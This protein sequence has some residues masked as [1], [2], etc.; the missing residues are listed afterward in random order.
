MS[1]KIARFAPIASASVDF[2]AQRFV[3]ATPRQQIAETS[4]PLFRS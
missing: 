2:L 4:E 1:V 3:D